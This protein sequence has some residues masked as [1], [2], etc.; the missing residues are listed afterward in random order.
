MGPDRH[1]HRRACG[2]RAGPDPSPQPAEASAGLSPPASLPPGRSSQD[3][4][5]A[6]RA[7][8]TS[9]P[10]RNASTLAGRNRWPKP[11]A[12]RTEPAQ[13]RGGKS[14]ASRPA[15]LPTASSKVARTLADLD[16][17]ETVGRISPGRGNLLPDGHP[18][19]CRRRREANGRGAAGPPDMGSRARARGS[20]WLLPVPRDWP[21]PHRRLGV[22]C[23]FVLR[24][25]PILP[26]AGGVKTPQALD[27]GATDI[28]CSNIFLV[29]QCV[30]ATASETTPWFV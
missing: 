29:F 17:A 3:R 19:G 10:I 24:P 5:R 8:L 6:L 18:N 23:F 22:R 11:D 15:P 12:R 25:C 7:A 9:A 4:F 2:Q 26:G 30:V 13:R 27:W 14:S 28:V 20:N 21:Y 1:P 16:G